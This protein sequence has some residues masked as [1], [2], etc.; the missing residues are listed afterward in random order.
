MP[1]GDH[2]LYVSDGTLYACGTNQHGDLGIGTTSPSFVPAFV[3]LSGVTSVTSS[4]RT[5]G[6]LVGG[7]YYSWGYNAMGAVGNGSTADALT[8]GPITL[9]APVSTLRLGRGGSLNG[10]TL[11]LLSDGTMWAW[12][13]DTCGQLRDGGRGFVTAAERVAT[14]VPYVAVE[15]CGDAW[16][17]LDA[18][19]NLWGW[20][21]NT[22]FQLGNGT[23]GTQLAPAVIATGGSER[24]LRQPPRWKF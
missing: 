14:P 21:D 13:A 20:G 4:W 2:A 19:G 3:S 24:S 16:Y 7:N 5:S 12:G 6:A 22:R 23:T 15:S 8:S 17:G 18:S 10:Q 11:A 9:P 1:P